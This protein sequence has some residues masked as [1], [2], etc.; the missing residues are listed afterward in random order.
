SAASYL[1]AIYWGAIMIA[2]SISSRLVLRWK[3]SRMI[4]GSA[5]GAAAGTAILLAAQTLPTAAAGIATV[6]LSLASI[7]PVTLGFA[8][9]RFE[10]YSGSVFGILFAIALVGGML[11]PWG[12][13][14]LAQTHGL[15]VA[16][17]IVAGNCLM[18]FVLQLGI[19]SIGRT[20]KHA[21]ST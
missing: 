18:I 21:Y 10:T 17:A 16:M 6:G 8:G 5:L 11:M 20:G 15:R 7:Y 19:G 9:G 4:L 3:P 12:V 1:L 2:R 14:Q 13:G